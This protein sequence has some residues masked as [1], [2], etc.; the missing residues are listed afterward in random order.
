ME[1]VYK[2]QYSFTIGFCGS[3][4]AME[5][6]EEHLRIKLNLPKVK[7]GCYGNKVPFFTH[8]SKISAK[9]IYDYLYNDATIYLKRKKLIYDK[10]YA[11]TEVTSI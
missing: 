3:L 11:N 1:T 7:V 9:R 5:N 6:I 2:R 8:S 10:V 4:T